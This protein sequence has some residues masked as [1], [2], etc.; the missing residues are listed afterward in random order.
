MNARKLILLS[1]LQAQIPS[2]DMLYLLIA[3]RA[4]VRHK[5][6]TPITAA[7]VRQCVNNFIRAEKGTIMNCADAYLRQKNI[8][9]NKWV[10]KNCNKNDPPTEIHLWVACFL[11][12]VSCGFLGQ[13]THPSQSAVVVFKSHQNISFEECAVQVLW[14]K[15]NR[16]QPVMN[17]SAAE[18]AMIEK[19][20]PTTMN[21]PGWKKPIGANR[22]RRNL[23][24][25]LATSTPQR[26]ARGARTEG[27]VDASPIPLK[28]TAPQ[29]TPKKQFHTKPA[30]SP[31]KPKGNWTRAW[32]RSSSRKTHAPTEVDDER[33]DP[34]Y[35][36]PENEA[37]EDL[38]F[39]EAEDEEPARPKPKTGKKPKK[40][41]ATEPR[42]GPSREPD[43]RKPHE[44]RF[45]IPDATLEKAKKDARRKDK[46][47]VT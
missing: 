5:P 32:T 31:L 46:H 20:A 8:P 17:L 24:E 14:L 19:P 12:D 4:N 27:P 42:P 9:W 34:T 21:V 43:G 35:T 23:R 2:Y 26:P 44:R 11:F 1:I 25:P 3:V 28:P 16:L 10:E 41:N 36:P 22:S 38:P 15:N 6:P 39:Q 33:T 47:K 37:P 7:K 18:L 29:T 30:P 45:G 40:P 13:A